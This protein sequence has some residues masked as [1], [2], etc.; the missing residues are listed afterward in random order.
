MLHANSRIDPNLPNDAN[1][2]CTL[3]LECML[4]MQAHGSYQDRQTSM[5]DSVRSGGSQWAG[6]VGDD[7]NSS[8]RGGRG[9][10]DSPQSR[11]SGGVFGAALDDSA[12]RDFA[13]PRPH[14]VLHA[15]IAPD[16]KHSALRE[17]DG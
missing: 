12:V 16:S 10:V 17:V 13:T 1:S 2:A 15:S 7:G 3:T 4:L 5:A 9:A 8:E 6:S 14:T 11:G